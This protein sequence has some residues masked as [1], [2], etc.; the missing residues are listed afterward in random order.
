MS[1]HS[2]ALGTTTGNIFVAIGT[3]GNVVS[4]S[5]FCNKSASS[6]T[7]SLHLVPTGFTANANNVIYSNKTITAGDTYIL[8]LEKMCLNRGDML[9]AVANTGN[10]I[11][12][13]VSALGI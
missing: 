10:A 8:E 5:Y 3:Q 12:A 2:T 7:F 9:Q 13:T 6:T 11:V 4:V 1:I